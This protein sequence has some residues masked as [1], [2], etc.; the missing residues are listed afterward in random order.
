MIAAIWASKDASYSIRLVGP[1]KT[2]EM[3][4]RAFEQWLRNFK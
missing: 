1:K 4:A 3:H 2:V